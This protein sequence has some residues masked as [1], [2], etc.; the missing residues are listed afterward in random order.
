MYNS[1]NEKVRAVYE[2]L[3]ET[4]EVRSIADFAAKL[5]RNRS[6][7]SEI[8]SGR[9]TVSDQLVFDI[10]KRFP[11]INWIF[12]TQLEC[13][14]MLVGSEG[15]VSKNEKLRKFIDYLK[16]SGVVRTDADFANLMGRNKGNL[17]EILS[18]K[19]NLT[20]QFIYDIAQKFPELNPNFLSDPDCA[21]MLID[22]AK[23]DNGIPSDLAPELIRSMRAEIIRLNDQIVWMRNLIDKLTE[24]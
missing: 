1:I 24:K 6:N 18:G 4:L 15:A 21:Q 16:N 22:D 5:S 9:G 10:V 2:Y 12:L 7:M 20:P 14:Q 13:E 3:K 8:L 11:F 17:S 23:V 19:N